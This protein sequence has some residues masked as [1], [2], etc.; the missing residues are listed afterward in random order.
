M[1]LIW[2]G[3]SC[4]R[5]RSREATIVTDPCPKSTGYA[6]G[7]VAADIVIISSEHPDHSHVAALTGTPL[8]IWGPGEYESSGVLITGVATSDGREGK[9]PKNN[10]YVIEAEGMRL[11]HL[12]RLSLPPT[13]EQVEEMSGVDVLLV[14]IGGQGMLNAAQAVET[15]SLLEP[16]LVVPMQYATQAATAKLDPLDPFLKEIGATAPIEPQARL[17]ITH[18]SL[19]HER[20]V[21]V[22]DFKR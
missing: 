3:H 22:L 7:K 12:G 15:I 2:L 9:E 18:S 21:A 20:E 6:I 17:S 16:K 11:C 10:V 4:F 13:S 1:E 5:I 14:P 19:P 8:I